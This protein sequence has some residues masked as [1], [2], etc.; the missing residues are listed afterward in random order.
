L[1]EFNLSARGG[2]GEWDKRD[3]YKQNEGERRSSNPKKAETRKLKRRTT[4]K[5]PSFHR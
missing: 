5:K 3:P 1:K 4:T 2:F